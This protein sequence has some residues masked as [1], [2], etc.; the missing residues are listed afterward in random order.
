M[1]IFTDSYLLHHFF[2]LSISNY[3]KLVSNLCDPHLLL[4]PLEPSLHSENSCVPETWDCERE[5]E[6][7]R[8]I[9]I[10]T[11][12]FFCVCLTLLWLIKLVTNKDFHLQT[13]K[14]GIIY[15]FFLIVL[16]PHSVWPFFFSTILNSSVVSDCLSIIYGP[17]FSFMTHIFPCNSWEKELWDKSSN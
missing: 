6:R 15:L 17:S 7:E 1:L 5:R 16:G 12:F 2:H 13:W 14:A 10:V 11:F 4:H 8:E 3:F 9:L